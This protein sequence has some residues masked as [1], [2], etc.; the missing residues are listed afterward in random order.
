M[1]YKLVACFKN[2]YSYINEQ[3]LDFQ[4]DKIINISTIDYITCRYPSET[5]LINLL[6]RDGIISGM[7][8]LSIKKCKDGNQT[9]YLSPL[10]NHI[11][12]LDVIDELKERVIYE[13]G[14]PR[15]YKLVPLNN[16]FF[17]EK[18]KEFY[19]YI[20]KNPEY[21]FHEIYND[22]PPKKLE[23]LVYNYDEARKTD[24]VSLED[25][26]QFD[27]LARKIQT[28]FSKYEVFRDYV[29]KTDKYFGNK[30]EENMPSF[31]LDNQN[32]DFEE[33]DYQEEEEF[34]TSSEIQKS[35][36]DQTAVWYRGPVP[37]G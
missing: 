18:K 29:V 4:E 14:K 33:D 3:E 5:F 36:S 31:S 28:E 8:H 34:L 13:D 9:Y 32:N 27:D 19:G 35:L 24:S 20:S 7:N 22:N 30:V 11:E 26:Y 1:S 15:T 37:R 12:M 6:D 25:L 17:Q 2:K 10:F 23:S 16:R 21:F